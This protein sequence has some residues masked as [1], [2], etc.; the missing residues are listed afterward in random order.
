MRKLYD[1]A[2][3]FKPLMLMYFAAGVFYEMFWDLCLLRTGVISTRMLWQTF[4][5]A[6]VVALCHY[7][8][9]TEGMLPRVP[10]KV[11]AALHLVC[12]YLAATGCA[13]GFGWTHDASL[14]NFLLSTGIFAALY[15]AAWYGFY[16]YYRHERTILNE[17]LQ[18]YRNG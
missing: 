9:Y 2:F 17:R 1:W 15:V 10:V 14:S 13:F 6:V 11:K 4:L 12:T 5:L 16:L 18:A 8:F 7:L 3:T